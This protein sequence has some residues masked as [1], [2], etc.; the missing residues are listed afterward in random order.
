ML[1]RL[2]LNKDPLL[3]DSLTNRLLNKVSL[4]LLYQNN[5]KDTIWTLPTFNNVINVY[6]LFAEAIQKSWQSSDTYDPLHQE[7]V[8]YELEVFLS[9]R[10]KNNR[11]D[12]EVWRSHF[13]RQPFWQVI[14]ETV[15]A[16]NE[17][18]QKRGDTRDVRTARYYALWLISEFQDFVRNNL[19]LRNMIKQELGTMYDDKDL[20]EAYERVMVLFKKF[21]VLKNN[22]ESK[23]KS[24]RN[25]P[26]YKDKPVRN[27][28]SAGVQTPLSSAG[29]LLAVPL[30]AL[31]AFVALR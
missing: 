7:T 2:E 3:L 13:L 24:V 28:S 31:V 4:Q 19:Q 9:F 30:L 23:D 25:K 18:L 5:K 1:S 16:Y 14:K 22:L 20:E 8:S 10:M 29:V 11:P 6:K 17:V 21:T 12:E 15:E 26:E 27:K